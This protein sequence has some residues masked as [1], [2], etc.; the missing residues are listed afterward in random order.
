M[1]FQRTY[2]KAAL[3][4]SGIAFVI[5]LVPSPAA[6]A[7]PS[8]A[9]RI[10]PK[11]GFKVEDPMGDV[12]KNGITTLNSDDFEARIKT[13]SS[14][15]ETAVTIS[16]VEVLNIKN[17]YGPRGTPYRGEVTNLVECKKEFAPLQFQFKL[18]SDDPEMID[19]IMGGVTSRF[20]FGACAKEQIAHVGAF[21]STYDVTGARVI[22]VRLFDKHD[23]FKGGLKTHFDHL[24]QIAQKLFIQ[25]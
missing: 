19:G 5:S 24:R 13:V 10:N 22:Q 1:N 17:L 21:F 20:L 12:V 14:N 8:E 25:K 23:P 2:Y 18:A 9:I 7:P 3:A 4:F 6:A 15:A 16:K 11:A